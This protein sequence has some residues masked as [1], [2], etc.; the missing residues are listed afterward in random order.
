VQAWEVGT[1]TVRVGWVRAGK[2]RWAGAGWKSASAGREQAKFHK[3][4]RRLRSC[5]AERTK[6][7][8]RADSSAGSPKYGLWAKSAS[9]WRFIRPQR[10]FANN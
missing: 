1:E 8:T 2:V 4:L 9:R 6:F 10:H 5:G 3:F 7:S